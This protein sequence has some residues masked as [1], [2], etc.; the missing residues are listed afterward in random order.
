ML[1]ISLS[2]ARSRHNIAQRTKGGFVQEP[3]VPA[4]GGRAVSVTFA[5][6]PLRRPSTPQAWRI[7]YEI[8][9]DFQLN[10]GAI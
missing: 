6:L 3:H 2:K 10:I 8:D 1:S 9:V 4:F 5:I 7:G